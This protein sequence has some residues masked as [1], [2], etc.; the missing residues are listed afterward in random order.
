MNEGADPSNRGGSIP[1]EWRDVV[2][3]V[4]TLVPIV[5]DRDFAEACPK[6]IAIPLHLGKIP[7]N[8]TVGP[9]HVAIAGLDEGIHSDGALASRKRSESQAT[10]T[11]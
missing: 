11:P 8:G 10:Q 6:I 7:E 1:R 9:G 2:H 4:Q 5:V 3:R